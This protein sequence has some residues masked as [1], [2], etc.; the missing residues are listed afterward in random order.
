MWSTRIV[1]LLNHHEITLSGRD[2]LI[3]CLMQSEGD[4]QPHAS[5]FVPVT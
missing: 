1:R 3:I 5:L 2:Q 4:G